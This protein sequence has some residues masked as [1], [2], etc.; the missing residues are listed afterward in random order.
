MPY[1]KKYYDQHP[2]AKHYY[3]A[4]QRCEN[5]RNTSYHKYGR[6]GI[7]C[8]ITLKD[9]KYLWFKDKAYLLKRPSINRKDP[10]G[11][12]T[13][14][15]CNFIEV[16]QNSREA[17]RPHAGYTKVKK[18]K[19]YKLLET[20][21]IYAN[22]DNWRWCGEHFYGDGKANGWEYAQEALKFY[23]GEIDK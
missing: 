12:Y 13:L 18:K 23:K 1:N 7:K 8:L 4:Q 10:D 15:N 14:E 19:L 17:R 6:K 22:R 11:H 2:W 16:S 21:E 20:L 5:K 3:N 9:F